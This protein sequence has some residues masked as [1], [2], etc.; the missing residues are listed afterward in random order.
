MYVCVEDTAEKQYFTLKQSPFTQTKLC[1]LGDF[2]KFN[3]NWYPGFWS[4]GCPHQNI[5]HNTYPLSIDIATDSKFY[6]T[7]FLTLLASYL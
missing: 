3:F 6:G 5:W 2:G 1:E 7:K 4:P